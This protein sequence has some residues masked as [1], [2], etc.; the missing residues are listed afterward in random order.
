MLP[1]SLDPR[2]A[3]LCGRANAERVAI[4]MTANSGQSH[5][6]VRTDSKLQPF[7]VMPA[8]E[9]LPGAIELQVVVL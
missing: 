4:R 2:R 8:E 1:Q 6:V 5:A 7:C 3:I 9:G